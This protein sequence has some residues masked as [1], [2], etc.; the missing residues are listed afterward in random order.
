[1]ILLPLAVT[2]V[3]F[4]NRHLLLIELGRASHGQLRAAFGS[5]L[6]MQLSVIPGWY[7]LMT[8]PYWGRSIWFD[9]SPLLV[10]TAYIA[11]L[12][13]YRHL[14]DQWKRS[15]AF[16]FAMLVPVCGCLLTILVWWHDR[17]QRRIGTN[18]THGQKM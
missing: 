17:H 11:E 7:E 10:T 14:D 8:A 9:L 15:L 3:T 6:V 2:W 16:K 5:V 4:R 13:L 18:G 1:V 12:L